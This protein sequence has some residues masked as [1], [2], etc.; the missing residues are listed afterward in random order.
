[1]ESFRA[2]DSRNIALQLTASM[3]AEQKSSSLRLLRYRE[4]APDLSEILLEVMDRRLATP[5]I[6]A[7]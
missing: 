3:S 2:D 7:K 1:M 5:P 6:P 4:T